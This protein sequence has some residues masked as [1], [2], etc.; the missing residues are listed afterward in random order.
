[1]AALEHRRATGEGQYID[2]SQAE[3]ALHLL[4]PALLD[5]TVNGR[6]WERAGNRDLVHAPHGRLP[7]GRD[8]PVDRHRL[9]QRRA[10]GRALAGLIG[11]DDL[12]ALGVDRPARPPGRARRRSSPPGP[13]ARTATTL[14]DAPPGA[15]G[16]PPTWC[17]TPASS[18]PTPRS[19]TAGT[20]SRSPT[21]SRAR[22]W[23]RA[24]RFRLSR[25]PATFSRRRAHLRRADVRGAR[26]SCCGYD[27]DRIADLAAA[28]LLE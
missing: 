19:C 7:D 25:T 9:H 24:A 27:G 23:S 2:L 12:A 22:R 18:P 28:E 8:R 10:P 5:Q 6:V 4:T 3:A 20:S 1:M 15:R 11:R 17:R 26:P 21:P 16:W 14:M 13:P